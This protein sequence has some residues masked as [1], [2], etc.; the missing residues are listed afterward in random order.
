MLRNVLAYMGVLLVGVVVAGA[1]FW[2]LAKFMDPSQTVG[3]GRQLLVWP[4]V[5]AAVVSFPL[6]QVSFNTRG[7]FWVFLVGVFLFGLVLRVILSERFALQQSLDGYIPVVI[8]IGLFVAG[9]WYCDRLVF[10]RD[11]VGARRAPK[12]FLKRDAAFLAV[13]LLSLGVVGQSFLF[14]Y[15]R[16]QPG[17]SIDLGGP[18]E[19]VAFWSAVVNGNKL[20][21]VP[22]AGT[23]CNARRRISHPFTRLTGLV[24][25]QAIRLDWRR[26]TGA[27]KWQVGL[28]VRW[29]DGNWTCGWHSNGSSIVVTPADSDAADIL[30]ELSDEAR[31]AIRDDYVTLSVCKSESSCRRLDIG[32]GG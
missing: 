6:V 15:L 17:Q 20:L 19:P 7:K 10:T 14:D 2:G 4:L 31:Q 12:R 11:A 26:P 9:F 28:A 22:S 24:G 1:A 16:S 3:G 25:G 32:P 27:I 29:S 23:P 13:L 21:A 5:I 18:E 8:L 30:I